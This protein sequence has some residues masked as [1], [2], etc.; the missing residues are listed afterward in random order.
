MADDRELQRTEQ[1]SA[2]IHVAMLNIATIL[3]ALARVLGVYPTV[4]DLAN[5]LFSIPLVTESQ[6]QFSF[7]WEGQWTFQVLPQGY[8]PS[9]TI[10]HGMVA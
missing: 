6:D 8:L 2:P 9:P 5:V 4:L 3:D 1:G 7:T 10:R